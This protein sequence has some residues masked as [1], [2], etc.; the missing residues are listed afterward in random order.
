LAIGGRWWGTGTIDSTSLAIS[1]RWWRSGAIDCTR[2]GIGC[3]WWGSGSSVVDGLLRRRRSV[4]TRLSDVRH[5]HSWWWWCHGRLGGSANSRG[6]DHAAGTST[7]LSRGRTV[8]AVPDGEA[9]ETA[10]QTN[11]HNDANNDAHSGLDCGRDVGTVAAETIDAAV[12]IAVTAVGAAASGWLDAALVIAAAVAIAIPVCRVVVINTGENVVVV[13]VVEVGRNAL[14]V[15]VAVVISSAAAGGSAAG[16][17]VC[18]VPT[19]S[20]A[21]VAV[22]A[23]SV[24]Y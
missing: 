24:I 8:D 2:L 21:A 12:V 15:G 11:T 23:R 13:V 18:K 9:N 20:T 1:G 14:I 7:A 19:V 16:W 17:L 22:T 6:H 10:K 4:R 3:R 5:L